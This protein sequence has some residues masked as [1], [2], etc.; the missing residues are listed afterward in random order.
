MLEE[1]LGESAT[2]RVHVEGATSG[3][4]DGGDHLARLQ[5]PLDLSVPRT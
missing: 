3:R 5:L 4:V 1:W 2:G